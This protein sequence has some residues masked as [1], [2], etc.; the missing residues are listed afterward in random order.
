MKLAKSGTLMVALAALLLAGCPGRAGPC[1]RASV[2][3]S[4]WK[5]TKLYETQL[6]EAFSFDASGLPTTNTG[7]YSR[8]NQLEK[9]CYQTRIK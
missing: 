2:W 5:P 1:A 6:F 8:L 3:T 9:Y 4:E 7:V